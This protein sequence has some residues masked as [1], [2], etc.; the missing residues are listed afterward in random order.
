[1]RRA[2]WLIGALAMAVPLVGQEDQARIGSVREA[3][4]ISGRLAGTAGPESLNWI[5]RGDRFTYTA[6]SRERGP[7]VLV[8][9]PVNLTAQALFA[10]RRLTLPGTEEP[11]QYRSFEFTD[12][13]RHIVFQTN[14]R[15]IYR[16]SGLADFYL[17]ALATEE[18]RLGARDARTAD[19]SPDGTRLGFE[20]G[21]NLFVVDL[22]TGAERPLTD[23]DG[24][25]IFNGVFDWVYEEE[26]GFAQAWKW[27]PDGRRIAYWQTDERGVP[28]IQLTDWEEQHPDWFRINYPKVGDE[29]PEVRIGVLTVDGD[30]TQWLDV[31]IEE[32]HYIPRIYW[33]SDPNTLAV[34]T[35]NRPQNHLRLFFFDVRTGERRLVMEERSDAWIDVFDFFAGVDHYFYFPDGTDE[36]FWVS[37]RDGYNHLYRYSYDGELLNQVTRG[38][39]VVT[40]VEGIDSESRTIYYT[41][42]EE[43]SLERHLYAIGFD[44]SSKRRLT[45]TRG[46]HRIDMGPN[47]RYYIDRWSNTETPRQV[48]LWATEDGGRKLVTI[49]DNQA[50]RDYVADVAYSPMELFEFTTSDGV[51]LD[52]S[53]IRPPEFDPSRAYPLLL[54]VYGGPGSQGVYDTWASNGW[55][56]YLAQQGYI[57]ANVNNRGSGNYGRDFMEI[58]YGELGKWEALD[59]AEAAGWFASQPWVDGDRMAIHGTSYGGFMTL[60]TMLRHPGVFALGMSNSPVTDWR[61]YDTI[62]TERYMGLLADNPDGYE[63]TSLLER[64]D[65]LEGYLLLVHSGLD[66]NVHPQNTMQM[67][68]ALARAGKDAELRFFPPGAH[69][70]AFDF[71]S[72]ITMTEVYTNLLCEHVAT[73]CTPMDLNQ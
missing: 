8:Y 46:T 71:A 19:L 64:A 7:E 31:G 56:Q 66:E 11:I 14:F 30:G 50:V 58:V 28:V 26:F 4:M 20:R 47:A 16:N 38:D 2:L 41:G 70:A 54:S 48:E 17:Y 32:E 57:V 10:P 63:R 62:Y 40:R 35:L 27:S 60:A 69:G 51:T 49:E 25:S 21:G 23:V 61:L 43:S 1:M 73:Q 13:S 36:F 34:V 29:N 44:G 65:Q 9:D 39:W 6:R 59:F 42:T 15:P 12:D 37:D 3:L 45:G 55:Q 22:A 52:G 18:L 68:T 72:Y 67:L 53:M 5:D 24:D 33:T